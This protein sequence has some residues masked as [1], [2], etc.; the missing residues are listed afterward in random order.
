MPFVENPSR[1]LLDLINE[2]KSE[3]NDEFNVAKFL[4][5]G[6]LYLHGSIP[7]SIRQYLL[8]KF[9]QID[10]IQHLVANSVVL[11]GMNLPIDGIFYISG[12]GN[13]AELKNLIGR[14]NRLNEV[15]EPSVLNIDKLVVPV[16][17]VEIQEFPQY[18]GGSLR[19]KN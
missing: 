1:E 14:V 13:M 19:S 15:F 18:K 3:F 6:I 16:H 5:K 10:E 4:K 17:F 9:R 8:L 12:G 2:L 11:A 7:N